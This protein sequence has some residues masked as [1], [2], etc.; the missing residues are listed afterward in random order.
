VLKS[1]RLKLYGGMYILKDFFM[2]MRKPNG[3]GGKITLWLMNIG[4]N[5]MAKWGLSYLNI[6]HDDIILDIGCGGGKN[7]ARMLK[8]TIGGKVYGLDYSQLS[9][10][11]SIIYNQK[12]IGE[13]KCEIRQGNVSKIPYS[14]KMFNIVTAFETIYFWPDIY[15][16]FREVYRILKPQGLFFICNESFRL[17]DEDKPHEY[18][19][20]MLDLKIYSV[21]ELK[22]IFTETG[23]GN[24]EINILKNNICIIGKKEK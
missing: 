10:N 14:D 23:F 8:K 24:I 11:N 9:V 3:L 20:K 16:S 15:N 21:N 2:N 19:T 6:K 18:F 7:I 22:K 4:H 12:A 5:K 13:N 17:N 1:K